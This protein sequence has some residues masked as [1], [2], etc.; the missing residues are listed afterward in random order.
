V[1][2]CP[3]CRSYTAAER[4]TI[5]NAGRAHRRQLDQIRRQENGQAPK[6]YRFPTWRQGPEVMTWHPA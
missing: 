3:A 6:P 1:T 2:D 4:R 5:D